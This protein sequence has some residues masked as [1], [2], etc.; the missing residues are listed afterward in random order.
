VSEVVRV[1]VDSR[2]V[3][4]PRGSTAL[5]AVRAADAA[6]A[7]RVTQGSRIITDSRGLPVAADAATHGGAIYRLVPARR[8]DADDDF[9]E[10]T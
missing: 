3:D 10:L 1:F 4:V 7:E 6:A 9:S 8:R 2:G 5:D